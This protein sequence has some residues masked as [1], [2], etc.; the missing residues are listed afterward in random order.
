MKMTTKNLE[1]RV[2]EDLLDAQSTLSSNDPAEYYFGLN[3]SLEQAAQLYEFE[4][5]DD[6]VDAQSTMSCSS[7]I[8]YYNGFIKRR[9]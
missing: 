5:T 7:P 6:L 2:E 4:D 8:E 1:D 3:Y 9:K